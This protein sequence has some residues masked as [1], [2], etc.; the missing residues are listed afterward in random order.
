MKPGDL[1]AKRKNH[2]RWG[3][4]LDGVGLI[5]REI[6]D[7]VWSGFAATTGKSP[8]LLLEVLFNGQVVEAGEYELEPIN[9]AR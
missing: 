2:W 8:P 1:V 5:L 3:D 4:V 9:E 7:P 6:Q